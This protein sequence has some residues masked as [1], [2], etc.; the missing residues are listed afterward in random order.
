[1][2][3]EEI[4]QQTG[5]WLPISGGYGNCLEDAIVVHHDADCNLYFIEDTVRQ[6]YFER[7]CAA[8]LLIKQELLSKGDKVYDRF[9]YECEYLPDKPEGIDLRTIYFDITE[10]WK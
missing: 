1:M 3:R 8:S 10:C 7:Y 6:Y 5:V 4:R 9:H 2:L